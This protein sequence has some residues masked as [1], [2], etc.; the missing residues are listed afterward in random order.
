MATAGEGDARK[1]ITGLRQQIAK[2]RAHLVAGNMLPDEEDDLRRELEDLEKRR[3]ICV[4][5]KSAGLP[6]N[7]PSWI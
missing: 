3:Q 2:V 4:A 1:R 6:G 5:A 7:G